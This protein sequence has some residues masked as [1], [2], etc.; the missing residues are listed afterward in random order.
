MARFTPGQY[1]HLTELTIEHVLQPGYDHGNEFEFGLDLMSHHGVSIEEI[2]RIAGHATTRTTE[3]VYRR[4]LRPVIT[5]GA[6]IMDE[7]FTGT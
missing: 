6:E 4:E 5:T 1:P 7:L 3:I 2:A